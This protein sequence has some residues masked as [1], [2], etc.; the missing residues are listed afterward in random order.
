MIRG[1]LLD[2][3]I[4]AYWFN[5]N[6]EPAHSRVAQSVSALPDPSLLR[7]SAIV[8][9]EIE[10][11]HRV[12]SPGSDTSVQAR[13]TRFIGENIP[14]IYEVGKATTIYYG[15]LKARLFER[16][17]PRE[18]RTKTQRLNQL[19]DPMTLRKLGIQENDIWIAAQAIEHNLVLVSH[20]Q[21]MVQPIRQV[22]GGDLTL[23]TEDWAA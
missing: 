18:K 6:R 15:P 1:Y 8:L 17:S 23:D 2:T 14:K 13:Y 7:T 19:V 21:K 16:F 11:G 3:N 12:Q 9:G 22:L 20:D 5:E 10:F 4:I